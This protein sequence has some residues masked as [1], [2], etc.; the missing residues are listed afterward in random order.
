[1]WKRACLERTGMALLEGSHLFPAVWDV[2]GFCEGD[3]D[4]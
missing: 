2:V 3:T 4:E 1:M